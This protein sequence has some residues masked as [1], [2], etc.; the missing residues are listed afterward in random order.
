MS[1]LYEMVPSPL[2]SDRPN[3]F[4]TCWPIDFARGRTDGGVPGQ[5]PMQRAQRLTA[6]LGEHVQ[7]QPTD[8]IFLVTWDHGAAFGMFREQQPNVSLL[9]ARTDLAH[10]LDDYPALRKF[11]DRALQET[12][13]KQF[14]DRKKQ[15]VPE[16]VVQVG[17]DVYKIDQAG[18]N[19]IF[20]SDFL[21]DQQILNLFDVLKA[22]NDSPRLSFN[23]D[24]Y[25]SLPS[26]IK[27]NLLTPE[28]QQ[29]LQHCISLEG[30]TQM[31]LGT[32]LVPAI[33][34]NDELAKAIR[35][36]LGE[37]RRASVV[38][39]MNCYMM[40]LHTLYSLKEQ[41]AYL[42]APQSDIDT[43]GYHYFKILQ[44]IYRGRPYA[45]TPAQLA[46]NCVEFS[47]APAQRPWCRGSGSVGRARLR[48]R[49]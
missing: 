28:Q 30:A 8:E 4:G 42:V 13:F 49:G 32:P 31:G 33:L 22:G 15:Q 25:H 47:H 48:S 23:A 38:L 39:M 5:H 1:L 27:A 11:W 19:T 45:V 17:F 3:T 41:V 7:L 37:K 35:G 29:R 40:N 36:W 18:P 12:R 6:V 46:I 24:R 44:S 9:T 20:T 14:V 34:K 2:G 21:S 26:D 10:Q 43:P 16:L